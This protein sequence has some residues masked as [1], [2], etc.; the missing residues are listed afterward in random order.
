MGLVSVDAARAHVLAACAPSPA[1]EVALAE[2]LGCVLAA[3]VVAIDDIPPFD[4][5]A[6][7]GFAVRAVDVDGATADTPV[8]LEVVDTVLAGHTTACVVGQG[9]AVR[10]MTGA[11]MP[12]GADAVVIVERTAP[13]DGG[14]SVFAPV[15]SGDNVRR[16]GDDLRAGVVALSAGARLRPAAL[17]VAA[18]AGR[19][20]VRVHRRPKVGVISTGDELVAPGV[21]LGP[22]QIRDTNRTVLLGL[23]A[24]DGFEPV[25]LGQVRDDADEI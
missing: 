10:I 3:D 12:P 5:S 20:T 21:P 16:A 22:G 18:G 15:A 11:P 17:G 13:S 14:V 4:N 8:V 9:Q 24:V 7:D 25:D 1:S 6:M 2:A 23:L 19:P